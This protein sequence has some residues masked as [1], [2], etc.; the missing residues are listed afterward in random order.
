MALINRLRFLNWWQL[1]YN[2]AFGWDEERKKGP[3]SAGSVGLGGNI[4]SS[5][6]EFV[7]VPTTKEYSNLKKQTD[8]T[9]AGDARTSGNGS[10]M[11]NGAVPVYYAKE[12]TQATIPTDNR[13]YRGCL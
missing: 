10:I 3:H 1:G 2:N 8:F 7:R 11:R 5:M 12:G 6:S 13:K 4:S 9:E